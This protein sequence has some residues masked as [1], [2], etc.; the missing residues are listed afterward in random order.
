[1]AFVA[2]LAKLS[3]QLQIPFLNFVVQIVFHIANYQCEIFHDI[4]TN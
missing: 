4:E 3:N 2:Y 1:M